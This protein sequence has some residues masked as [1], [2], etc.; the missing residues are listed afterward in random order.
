MWKILTIKIESCQLAIIIDHRGS[1]FRKRSIDTAVF[2][3]RAFW[4][5]K[6]AVKLEMVTRRGFKNLNSNL[7]TREKTTLF[8]HTSITQPRALQLQ[9]RPPLGWEPASPLK[10]HL[11]RGADP[12]MLWSPHTSPLLEKASVV[13]LCWLAASVQRPDMIFLFAQRRGCLS[14]S[15][16]SGGGSS[17]LLITA[18]P[19]ASRPSTAVCYTRKWESRLGLVLRYSL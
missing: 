1:M 5:R 13:L 10:V 16:T 15:A 18:F 3:L 19:P 2:K 7:S 9:Q 11:K 17:G 4:F 12:V 14:I 6:E 8:Q